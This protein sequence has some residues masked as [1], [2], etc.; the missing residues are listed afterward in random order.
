MPTSGL[1]QRLKHSL[2]AAFGPRLR[3]VL[4][5][6]SHARGAARPD[7]DLDVMVLLEGPVRQG[8]D[9]DTAIRAIYPLQL[10]YELPIH[11]VP[12]DQRVFDAGEFALYREARREGKFL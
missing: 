10:D 7:S 4:V 1:Y 9:L 11:A 8:A 5:Y 2:Q 3:G 6:G 12:V